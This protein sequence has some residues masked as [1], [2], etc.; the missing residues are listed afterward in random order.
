MIAQPCAMRCSV[1]IRRGFH[2][3]IVG[4]APLLFSG[5]LNG[6]LAED[7]RGAQAAAPPDRNDLIRLIRSKRAEIATARL[8]YS[9]LSL[10]RPPMRPLTKA[11]LLTLLQLEGSRNPLGRLREVS[12]QLIDGASSIEVVSGSVKTRIPAS[13]LSG[14]VLDAEFWYSSGSVKTSFKKADFITTDRYDIRVDHVNKVAMIFNPG[15]SPYAVGR[16]SDF[17]SYPSDGVLEKGEWSF[18]KTGEFAT[19][20]ARD[21]I[22]AVIAT[23]HVATGLVTELT[24]SQIQSGTAVTTYQLLPGS[25]DNLVLPTVCIKCNTDAAGA[26][27]YLRIGVISSAKFNMPIGSSVFDPEIPANYLAQDHRQSLGHPATK[28]LKK[29]IH[30]SILDPIPPITIRPAKFVSQRSGS[31]LSVLLLW[32]AGALLVIAAGFGIVIWRRK[33]AN[34]VGGRRES[35]VEWPQT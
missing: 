9:F 2:V 10:P 32:N 3:V 20:A 6:P 34:R 18:Y 35:A 27:T 24:E 8:Q 11:E 4:I 15:Q 29:P 31:R 19:V 17:V 30:F 22:V 12:A 33:R 21:A 28:Y 1:A 13:K 5:T 26:I 25:F 16:L 14:D 7:A 23:V